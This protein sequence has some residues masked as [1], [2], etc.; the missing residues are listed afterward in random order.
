MVRMAVRLWLTSTMVRPLPHISAILWA[1]S[2]W[3]LE[4]PPASASSISKISGSRWDIT[5]KPRRE[6]M[7]VE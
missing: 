2:A 5:A 1:V 4:S 6:R 7:P 3:N